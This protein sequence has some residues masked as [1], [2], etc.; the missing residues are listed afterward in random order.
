LALTE[1]RPWGTMINS[2]STA[3]RPIRLVSSERPVGSDR[4]SL[5]QQVIQDRIGRQLREMYSELVDQPVPDHLAKLLSQLD[6][7]SRGE[8]E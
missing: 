4:D 1:A 2:S 5:T 8:Q 6:R 7:E 3:V